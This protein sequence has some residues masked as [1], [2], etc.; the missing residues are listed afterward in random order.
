MKV[1][2]HFVV[3]YSPGTFVAETNERP[4]EAWNVDQ[5]VEMARNVL[6]RHNATPYAF[7]FITRGREDAD[8]DSKQIASSHYYFLG[9]KVESLEE[10]EARNDPKEETLRFNMRAND[11][12][13]IITNTNSWRWTQP[14][15]DED[16][17]LDFTS[18]PAAL[19]G[20]EA[21]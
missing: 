8:L 15:E 13:R 16:V 20:S 18:V 3:F 6:Q 5:A 10:V 17:V 9:G 12:K 1:E 11:Y 4:I 2:K 19:T 21:A 7:R 14:L